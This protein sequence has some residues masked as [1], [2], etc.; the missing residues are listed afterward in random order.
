MISD[1]SSCL[2]TILGDLDALRRDLESTRPAQADRVTSILNACAQIESD[3]E[4]L[5]SPH[6]QGL[7]S[8]GKEFFTRWELN[9]EG[10]YSEESET[11]LKC[12]EG[13]EQEIRSRY[14][15]FYR[16]LVNA[17]LSLCPSK[18]NTR[19]C[20]VGC[21]PLPV[22]LFLWHKRSGCFI[23]GIDCD[24]NASLAASAGFLRKVERDPASYDRDKVSFLC[25][26]GGDISYEAFDVVLLSSSVRGKACIFNRIVATSP[27]H[28]RIV[29]R[30]P[31]L[32][33]RHLAD[34]EAADL[35]GLQVRGTV[36][37]DLIESRILSRE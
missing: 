26:D 34:W 30:T 33:W 25:A 14:V 31:R 11:S 36:H 2:E 24:S 22:S 15:E 20:H 35:R 29:E 27:S 19:V 18:P 10:F 21:G 9:L 8:F 7:L 12:A 32:F 4:G 13:H 5:S 37:V 1:A 3:P 23:T 6:A 17:E 28:V 16:S